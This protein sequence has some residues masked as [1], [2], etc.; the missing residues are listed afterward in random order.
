M[1]SGG[2]GQKV[3][4]N[5]RGAYSETVVDHVLNPHNVGEMA[6]ADGFASLST[7]DADTIRVWLRVKADRVAEA[8]FETDSCAATA[9][10]SSIVTE[11]VT[12]MTIAEANA[13]GRQDVLDALDGLP[14][15]NV[16]CAEHSVA[17]LKAALK[18]YLAIKREPWKR[19]FRAR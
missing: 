16:H 11:L 12:G 13:I 1:E 19:N 6:N 8:R 18:D 5:L 3:I 4:D 9:A 17:A 14:E 7:A 15:G 10:C 2:P